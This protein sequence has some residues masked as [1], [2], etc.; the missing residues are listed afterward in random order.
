MR[1]HNGKNVRALITLNYNIAIFIKYLNDSLHEGLLE[2][3]RVTMSKN[4]LITIFLTK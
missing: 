3:D 2:L 4:E 1:H